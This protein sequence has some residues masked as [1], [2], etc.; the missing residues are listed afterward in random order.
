MRRLHSVDT[1]EL[2]DDELAVGTDLD[3]AAPAASAASR[4]A[5]KPD[6]SATL[7]VVRPTT[8]ERSMP[9]GDQTPQEDGPGLPRQAP[10]K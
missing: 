5:R 6:H 2:L 4:A 8:P 10:S 9:E 3:V 7:F 1:V